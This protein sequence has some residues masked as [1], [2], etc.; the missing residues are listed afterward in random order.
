[1]AMIKR[2]S[3]DRE[4]LRQLYRAHAGRVYAYAARR[5]GPHEAEDAVAET[6]LVAWRK[7]DLAQPEPIPWLLSV[8]RNVIRNQNRT[9][10]RRKRLRLRAEEGAR[11]ALMERISD[12]PE[13][14]ELM[15]AFRTLSPWLQEAFKL[16]LWD[17]LSTKEAAGVLGCR[18]GTLAVRMHRARQRLANEMRSKPSSFP[19]ETG[20]TTQP[21][22][23]RADR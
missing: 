21:Q 17:G 7:M 19:A 10:G 20:P 18:P 15:R 4:A 8:T 5:V 23:W 22:S 12:S 6:F 1:M 16:T 13:N 11:V 3:D 14:D 2:T 9:E